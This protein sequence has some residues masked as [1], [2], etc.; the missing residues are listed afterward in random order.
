MS[1][2]LT[3]EEMRA[4]RNSGRGRSNNAKIKVS[5]NSNNFIIKSKI[6]YCP[7]FER[8][9]CSRKTGMCIKTKK[10]CTTD[11]IERCELVKG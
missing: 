1:K 10:E 11:G 9:C 6:D 3:A 4:I 7:N 2:I 5:A 8:P